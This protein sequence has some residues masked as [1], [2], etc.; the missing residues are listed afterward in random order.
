MRNVCRLA[1]VAFTLMIRILNSVICDGRSLYRCI[2]AN[3]NNLCSFAM[4]VSKNGTIIAVRR[5][6]N[7]RKKARQRRKNFYDRYSW[8]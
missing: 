2:V 3:R 8:A 6:G 4:S 1:V 7:E 5:S